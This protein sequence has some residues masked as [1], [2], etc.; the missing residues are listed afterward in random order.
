MKKS[1]NVVRLRFLK[2]TSR[3]TTMPTFNLILELKTSR[4]LARVANGAWPW[5][6]QISVTT[7]TIQ[8]GSQIIHQPG[9]WVNDRGRVGRLRATERKRLR[10]WKRAV[11]VGSSFRKTRTPHLWQEDH[12]ISRNPKISSC[13][14]TKDYPNPWL[15]KHR[16]IRHRNSN[17][18]LCSLA[19]TT[20]E[21][22][23]SWRNSSNKRVRA[24]AFC[25][26]S[27]NTRNHSRMRLSMRANSKMMKTG[28]AKTN[29]RSYFRKSHSE[30]MIPIAK[31]QQWPSLKRRVKNREIKGV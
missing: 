17:H 7:I 3:W 13:K 5:T 12:L 28:A 8:R 22:K 4:T 20:S 26:R 19:K 14:A 6:P 11:F 15:K 18:F 24:L 1:S 31:V 30:F 9:E 2:N 21:N 10:E 29:R 25:K 16:I 23:E 27:W